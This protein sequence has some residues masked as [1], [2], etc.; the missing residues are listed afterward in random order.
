MAHKS[1][2]IPGIVKGGVAVPQ[3][4]MSLPEGTRVEIHVKP[5]DMTPDLESELDQWDKA[6]A[7]AWA[8]IDKW[9][10]ESP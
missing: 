2:V 5:A 8:M 9:E 4:E 6:S 10:A 1:L 3:H 7:E